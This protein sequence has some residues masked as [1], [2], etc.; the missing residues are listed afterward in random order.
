MQYKLVFSLLGLLLTLFSLSMLLPAIVAVIYAE[1]NAIVFISSFLLTCMSGGALWLSSR[2]RGR[3]VSF[4]EVLGALATPTCC[5][6]Q[7][8]SHGTEG[9]PAC[10]TK[11]AVHAA[12]K[13]KERS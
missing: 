12:A 13:N 11:D 4:V 1:D 10:M 3:H 7:E 2:S 6:Y 5:A 8:A 9:I